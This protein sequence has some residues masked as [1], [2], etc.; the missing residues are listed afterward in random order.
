MR[1]RTAGLGLALCLALASCGGGSTGSQSDQTTPSSATINLVVADTPSTNVTVLSFEVQI[2]AA[3]LQPGSV[4]ILPRPVTVDLAQLVS[5]TGFLASTVIDSAT[6]TSLEITF[7]N[8]QVT[9]LNNTAAPIPLPGQ[10]CAAGATC[11]FTP[12]LNNASVTVSSGVFP[13]TLT[14]SS[15]TGLNLDL[16]I[17]DLLQSDLSVTLANGTS[18]NLS[19]L[20]GKN[21][22]SQQASIDDVLGTI[23]AISGSQVSVTTAFGDSLVLTGSTSTTYTYPDSVCSAANASCLAA[24]QI[25]TVDLNL[26]GDGSLGIDSV[27]YLGGSGSPLVKGLVLSTN[28]SGAVSSAQL[29]LQRGINV[30]SLSAGQVATVTLPTGVSY[31]VGPTVYPAISGASFASAVDLLPGQ[32]LILSVG[33]DLVA[34]TTPSFS[35]SSIYLESSQLVGAVSSVDTGDS[36]LDLDGLSGLFTGARPLIQQVNVQTGTSTTFVGFASS[37]LAAVTAG[38]FIAAKGPLLNTSS[39][40]FPTVGAVELRARASGSD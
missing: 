19:L 16:S 33:S 37:S 26:L 28:T 35:T 4:A 15:T 20:S 39:G 22:T 17:P 12:T 23:T 40:G 5:D 6:Y 34:G 10:S 38:Q 14:A 24:G 31:V 7:A 3:V 29:L 21:G 18:V 2:T 27:S 32:E 1:S 30:S 25:V 11:T 9:I 13:L 36:S 8:P